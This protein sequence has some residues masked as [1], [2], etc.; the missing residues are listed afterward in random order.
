MPV[1]W[2]IATC[3]MTTD[4]RAATTVELRTYPTNRYRI[5]SS[6]WWHV[7]GHFLCNGGTEA[8]HLVMQRALVT[9]SAMW[10]L[11]RLHIMSQRH[12]ATCPAMF[13]L[14]GTSHSTWI[15]WCATQAEHD[16]YVT[17][18]ASLCRDHIAN[19]VTN[20]CCVTRRSTSVLPLRRKCPVTHRHALDLMR[21][22]LVG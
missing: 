9:I 18:C 2:E 6:T 19:A 15:F 1:F 20:A 16:I 8:E 3:K 13:G 21:C 14:C 4:V 5:R 22:V 10:S 12:H 7:T 11:H 17:W